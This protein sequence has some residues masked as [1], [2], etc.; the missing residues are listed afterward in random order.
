[1]W[2][3]EIDPVVLRIGL[4]RITSRYRMPVLITENGLGEYDKLTEDKQ[5][6]DDY[7]INYLQSHVKGIK[8]AI[9]DGAEV[10]GYCTWSYT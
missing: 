5:L 3:R 9:S 4:R 10:L 8:E 1:N 2:D 7:R 6:H